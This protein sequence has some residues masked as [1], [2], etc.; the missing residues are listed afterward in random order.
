VNQ[1]ATTPAQV[2]V[3]EFYHLLECPHGMT[4]SKCYPRLAALKQ[5]VVAGE[6]FIPGIAGHETFLTT[7]A[8]TQA[9]IDAY[10]A[11][12]D[13]KRKKKSAEDSGDAAR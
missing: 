3:H 11:G 5:A 2:T 6:D 7:R 9:A 1:I 8:E 10:Y 12:A 13:A 4:L